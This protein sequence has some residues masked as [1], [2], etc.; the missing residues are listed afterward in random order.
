MGV[1][2]W[3]QSNTA[4]ETAI[5]KLLEK[6]SEAALNRDYEK[7]ISYYPK[8]PDVAFGFT[9]IFPT[10]MVCSYD[11]LPEFCKKVIHDNPVS[12]FESFEFT[13]FQIRINGAS[14]FATYLHN[15]T[16]KDGTKQQRD[17]VEYIEKIEGSGKRSDTFSH[18]NLELL[19][20]RQIN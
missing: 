3:G 1:S 4:E 10:N 15:S 14:A 9:T 13:D 11:K 19:Q 16:M 12:S 2:I 20:V 7:W 18:K 8:F 6:E 5:I 17:K